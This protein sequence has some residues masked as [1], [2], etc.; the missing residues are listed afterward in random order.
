MRY[1]GS[2]GGGDVGDGGLPGKGGR[3]WHRDVQ[4]RTLSCLL[5]KPHHIL[6]PQLL[7][8]TQG[9]ERCAPS[10]WPCQVWQGLFHTDQRSPSPVSL[11]QKKTKK[12]KPGMVSLSLSQQGRFPQNSEDTAHLPWAVWMLC[13]QPM[14]I[15]H[16]THR[17]LQR[18]SIAYR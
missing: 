17:L 10:G 13:T 12:K 14:D 18:L 6:L 5:H 2:V 16:R 8:R 9:A 3:G 4:D 7:W 15:T 11:R 1:S